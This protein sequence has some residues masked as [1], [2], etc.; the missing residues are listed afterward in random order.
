MN[1]I[2]SDVLPP[3]TIIVSEDLYQAL[4]ETPTEAAVRQTTQALELQ[5][6]WEALKF[7]IAGANPKRAQ[8]PEFVMPSHLSPTGRLPTKPLF[9]EL[10]KK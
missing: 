7:A 2:K 8:L 10:P 3:N 4:T 6:V 9:Q 1:V 5:R